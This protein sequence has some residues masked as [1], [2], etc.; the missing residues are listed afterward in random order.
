MKKIVLLNRR[1]EKTDALEALLR[2]LFPECE[3]C[4]APGIDKNSKS[5][6]HLSLLRAKKD[7]NKNSGGSS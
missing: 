3:I 2:T 5:P 7:K 6:V 4:S 1:G